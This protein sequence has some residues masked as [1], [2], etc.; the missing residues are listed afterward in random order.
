MLKTEFSGGEWLYEHVQH[1]WAAPDNL[2]QWP[3]NHPALT[4][5]EGYG[6][7]IGRK[8]AGDVDPE[9]MTAICQ[10]WD[11]YIERYA[12]THREDSP[13]RQ[14]AREFH[15]DFVRAIGAFLDAIEDGVELVDPAEPHRPDKAATI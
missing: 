15:V 13:T 12:G 14:A 5:P 2:Y 9:L 10:V 7:L 6:G 3:E 1:L 11:E 8:P 4:R